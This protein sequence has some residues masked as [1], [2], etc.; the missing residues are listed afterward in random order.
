M[1]KHLNNGH[2]F[3]R[4]FVATIEGWLLLRGFIQLELAVQL[5]FGPYSGVGPCSWTV[6]LLHLKYMCITCVKIQI[7][8]MCRNIDILHVQQ[9]HVHMQYMCKTQTCITHVVL[10]GVIHVNGIHLY[11]MCETCV[12]LVYYTCITAV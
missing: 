6:V 10:H 2:P 9:I 7:Y 4:V 1:R 11:Y 3:C 8:Y 12:L 5:L